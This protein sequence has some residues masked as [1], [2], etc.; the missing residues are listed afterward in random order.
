MPIGRLFT[1]NVAKGYGFITN[2]NNEKDMF[3]HANE[4]AK[5]G[6]ELSANISL[7]GLMLEY[8][9]GL[10]KNNKK[11]ALNIKVVNNSMVCA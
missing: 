2:G 9:V 11:Q 1:Y 4:L 10:G 7:L 6:I 3:V 5:A 8:E